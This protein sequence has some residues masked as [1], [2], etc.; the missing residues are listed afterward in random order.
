LHA[1]V[2]GKGAGVTSEF[3]AARL[4]PAGCASPAAPDAEQDGG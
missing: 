2:T 4:A 1:A 3:A